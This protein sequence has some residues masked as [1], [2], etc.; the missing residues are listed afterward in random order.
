M[1]GMASIFGAHPKNPRQA[2][3]VKPRMG[4]HD[5]CQPIQAE[6]P[7]DGK[8]N[9]AM[10]DEPRDDTSGTAATVTPGRCL[11]G[12]ALAGAIAVALYGLTRAIATSLAA[13]PL[14]TVNAT[15]I[16]L[17]VAVRTLVV[18][19]ATLST[20]IFGLVA[21]GLLLLALQLLGRRPPKSDPSP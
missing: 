20:G 21:L 11:L 19:L 7:P 2:A 18:G 4:T 3:A 12:S 17:A 15:A 13:K 1:M 14:P 10:S 6:L 5:A 9:D 16:N 8:Q